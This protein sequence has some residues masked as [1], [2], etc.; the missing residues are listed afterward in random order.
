MNCSSYSKN[1]MVLKVR[2]Y[3]RFLTHS[4]YAEE[5]AAKALH[6]AIRSYYLNERFPILTEVQIQ[7][8]H[9]YVIGH[10]D[11]PM[12]F[13]MNLMKNMILNN[14]AFIT[15]FGGIQGKLVEWQC[16]RREARIRSHPKVVK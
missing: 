3:T 15:I 1:A 13:I 7:D 4:K 2:G 9:D 8:I 16:R 12:S 5:C 11:I 10:K 6:A 14:S